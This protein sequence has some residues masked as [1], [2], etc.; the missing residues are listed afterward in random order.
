[1]D[2]AI[3]VVGVL[4]ALLLGLFYARQRNCDERVEKAVL[5]AERR[6]DNW[7]RSK[8]ERQFE[9][10]KKAASNGAADSSI[11]NGDSDAE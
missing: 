8:N 5:D 6:S 10:Y 4:N 7:W 11:L 9:L 1:M 3:V 2:A